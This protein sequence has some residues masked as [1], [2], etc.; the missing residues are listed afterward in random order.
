MRQTNQDGY[1]YRY[2]A[3]II[4]EAETPLAV[5]SGKYDMLT[6]AI[7]A[8]DCNGLPY[9]PGSSIAGVVRSMMDKELAK[10]IFGFQQG[11]DGHGSEIIFTEARIL[12]S[13]GIAIDGLQPEAI[14]DELLEHYKVLPIRQHVRI[15]EYGTAEKTG[16]YD[17]EIVYAGTR[18]CFEIEMLSKTNEQD[19]FGKII[20]NLNDSSFR[21]GH[22]SRKGFGSIKVIDLQQKEINLCDETQ[23][24][25]YIKKLSCLNNNFWENDLSPIKSKNNTE[26]WYH[27]DIRLKPKDYMMFSSGMGDSDADITPVKESRVIWS[28][29]GR[30][31]KMVDNLI[32]IP[33][34]SIKGALAHR[35]AYH[36]NKNKGYYAGN[37][38]AK[39]GENNPAV[40]SLFGQAGK[41]DDDAKR[42]NV[43]FSDIIEQVEHTDKLFNH[44]A[45]DRITGGKIDGALY[46]NKATFL[47]DKDKVFTLKILV[48]RSIP[49]DAIDAFKLALKD[50]AT[51][52]LPLG[53]G[54]NNG[55]G[56]FTAEVYEIE[57]NKEKKYY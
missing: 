11:N 50:L 9:I 10:K 22:G 18:F 16:K 17:E 34:A 53:G 43:L 30:N 52:M 6:D 24:E 32:L 14:N 3:R 26:D 2:L 46:S 36:W 57:N 29:D 54:V 13:N 37:Q 56:F 20:A 45:L 31:G 51:G 28:V 44:L 5:G 1:S 40:I 7:V 15:N 4:I 19:T 12:N 8:K 48:S 21:L 55:F 33:A 25:E 41:N 47:K 42:G 39:V 38:N 27:Y 49:E 23:R 35:T